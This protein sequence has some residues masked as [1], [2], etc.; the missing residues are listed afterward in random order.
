MMSRKDFIQRSLKLLQEGKGK[1]LSGEE[2]M[3]VASL[4]IFP[5]IHPQDK[6]E[7][8]AITTDLLKETALRLLHKGKHFNPTVFLI[9]RDKFYL[10]EIEKISQDF[11]KKFSLIGKYAKKYDCMAAVFAGV[12]EILIKE[13]DS[14]VEA[15][16]IISL[17]YDESLIFERGEDNRIDV[18]LIKREDKIELIEYPKPLKGSSFEEDDNVLN[19]MRKPIERI[20]SLGKIHFN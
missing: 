12:G 16:F 5:L 11:S 13:G 10:C 18:F 8:F 15:L 17:A 9:A 3:K 19:G 4:P 7:I 14:F 6:E 20:I 1:L 2:S